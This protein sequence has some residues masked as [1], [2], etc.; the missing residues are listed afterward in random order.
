MELETCKD[1]IRANKSMELKTVCLMHL[2]DR[3]SNEGVF[4]REV[5]E[6]VECPVYVANKGL[7][8]ELAGVEAEGLPF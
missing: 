2:S 8:Y 4:Q 1:F 6:L 5:Q 3:T 7:E